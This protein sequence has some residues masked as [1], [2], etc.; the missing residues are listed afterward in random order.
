MKA[1]RRPT[2]GTPKATIVPFATLLYNALIGRTKRVGHTENPRRR[3]KEYM[4]ES[5]KYR[6]RK[7]WQVSPSKN[8]KRD[9]QLLLTLGVN[10]FNKQR[11]SNA[12]RKPGFV[13][14]M[15]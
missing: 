12:P 9:E 14:G 6:G 1:P 4:R 15:I 8:R 5:R 2:R 11:R 13:Y 7:T 10:R 3:F